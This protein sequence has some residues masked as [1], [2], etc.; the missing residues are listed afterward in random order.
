MMVRIRSYI[1]SY[2]DVYC[3]HYV[4]LNVWY[5][6]LCGYKSRIEL[7]TKFHQGPIRLAC[8]TWLLVA[9]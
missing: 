4:H 9:A 6:F 5:V 7:L 1:P 8:M 3:L 2:V